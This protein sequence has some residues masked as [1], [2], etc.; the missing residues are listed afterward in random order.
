MWSD[1]GQSLVRQP[2][3]DFPRWP[4]TLTVMWKVSGLRG[5]RCEVWGVRS[6]SSEVC[7]LSKF[8]EVREVWEVWEVWEVCE[9]CEVYDVNTLLMIIDLQ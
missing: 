9:V 8:C 5:V 3:K 1:A 2:T 7:E 6:V 4:D